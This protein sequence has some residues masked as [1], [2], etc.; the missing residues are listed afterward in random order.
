MKICPVCDETYKDDEI[1]FCLADGATLLKKKNGNAK[2]HSRVN[3][4]VAVILIAFAILV[5]LCLVSFNAQDPSF[6]TASSQRTQNWI[7]PF[8]AYFG[9]IL[10]QAIGI[11]AYLFPALVALIA[12]RVFRSETLYP[13]TS[14]V[15]GFLLFSSRLPV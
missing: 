3:E 9:D 10:F 11:S 7:G 8:G 2:K 5:F 15:V 6:N 14:R 13:R 1:N 12:W 4:V